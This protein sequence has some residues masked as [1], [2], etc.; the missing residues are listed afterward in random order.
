VIPLILPDSI[1]RATLQM[2]IDMRSEDTKKPMTE[3]ALK[4]LLNKLGRLESA[5]HCPNL[6]LERSIINTWQDV[7]PDAM[8]M[9]AK[10][11]FIEL[12]SDTSWRD[13][14]LRVVK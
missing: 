12:H 14:P 7:H 2:F 9:K 4:M 5:G 11:S 3:R 6:L 10:Q 13:I 1:D 8:T